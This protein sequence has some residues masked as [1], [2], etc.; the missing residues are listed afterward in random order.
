MDF[1]IRE[2]VLLEYAAGAALL[3]T[4]LG[5]SSR[6]AVPAWLMHATTEAGGLTLG[7]FGADGTVVG[8]SF[9]V[10]ARVG[11]RDELLS[12]GL[13]IAGP[14]RAAGAGR[15]LKEAQRMEALR[16][17]IER[18]R[19][20]A[21]PLAAPALRLYLTHLGARM[22]QYRVALYDGVREGFEIPQDDVD[23]IWDLRDSRPIGATE[24][25]LRIE[26]PYDRSALA[27]AEHLQWRLSVREQLQAALLQGYV[28]T[29]VDRDTATARAWLALEGPP[30]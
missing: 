1:E 26:L 6:D 10:A 25:R 21:D 28:G 29:G 19:W 7:A 30:A 3:G 12:C 17:G 18:I 11:D 23:V 9:A 24:S 15:A 4:C 8:W 13:A 14:R 20:T 2:P 27:A 22:T 16:R 5:F